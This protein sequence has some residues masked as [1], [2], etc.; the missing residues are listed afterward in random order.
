MPA[1]DYPLETLKTYQGQTPCPGDFD[2][3]WKRALAELKAVDARPER[4]LADFPNPVADC[5]HYRFTGVGGARIYAKLLIPQNAYPK[6]CPA[7]CFFHGYSL[8]SPEWSSLLSWAASG[9]VVAALDCRGQGGLSEEN[10]TARLSTLRGHIIRGLRE[11]PE[12]LAYRALFLDTAQLAALVM[13]MLEVDPERVCAVGGSQGGGLTL[14][15]A[16]L[17]PRVAR[18]APWHPFLS[19]YYRVWQMDLAENAYEELRQFFRQHDPQ[20]QREREIFETLGYIDVQH[21]ASRIRAKTFMTICLMDKICPPSTQFAAYNK[22]NAP[23][24]LA[25]YYDHGH[26]FLTGWGDMA[27]RFFFDWM[28]Q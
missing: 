25:I 13:N 15:C 21:L 9:F 12:K 11:G 23:K 19:D 14:A 27:Y 6:N 17:E 24:E 16:A 26:E 20:H 22:I 4:C 7:L 28:R 2:D 1:F 10:A 5:Y 8:S 18:I 3:Y